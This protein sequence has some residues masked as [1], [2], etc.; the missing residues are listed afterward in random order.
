MTTTLTN[1]LTVDVED[2]FQVQAFTDAIPRIA[3]D[4]M[5]CRVEASTDHILNLFARAGVIG[6]FFT[7][8]WIAERHPA[9]VRRIVAAGHELACH[10]YFHQPVDTQ[11]PADFRA[12]IRHAKGILEDLAGVAVHGYRAPTFSINKTNFW[13]FDVLEEEG[14]RYSSSIYPIRH[15]RYGVPDAPRCPFRPTNGMLWEIPMT[16]LRLRGR[17]L[18]CAGGGWF[19]LLPYELFRLSLRRYNHTEHRPGIFYI[20]PWE[21]DAGQPRIATASRLSCLRH[22]VGIP[23]VPGRLERLLRDFA[24]SRMDRAF[25]DVISCATRADVSP[26]QCMCGSSATH[27]DA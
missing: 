6:T 2:Y 22:Y 4:D 19:R 25:A 24:W 26:I 13:A 9:L 21:L 10:G 12:D 5:P 23:R 7:L 3:W 14:F 11:N 27:I 17:N 18:P 20:H 1:A 8:G 16:T 15:D